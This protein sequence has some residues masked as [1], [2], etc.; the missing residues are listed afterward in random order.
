MNG[1]AFDGRLRV[2]EWVDGGDSVG[3]VERGGDGAAWCCLLHYRAQRIR[4]QQGTCIELNIAHSMGRRS[5]K[6]G[7]TTSDGIEAAVLT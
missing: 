4:W 7:T 5:D 1:C 2:R 6:I 3:G